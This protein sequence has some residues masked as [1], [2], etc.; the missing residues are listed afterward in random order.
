MS[1]FTV[2]LSLDAETELGEA[3]LAAADRNAVVAAEAEI[4][5]RLKGA[6]ASAGR[7]LHE[8]LRELS[9]PPLR[10]LFTVSEPDRTV[11][12][13]TVRLL[14]GEARA[15]RHGGNGRPGD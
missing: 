10:M 4:F 12:V 2:I 1:S 7:D 5:R 14:P 15:D 9:F 13:E 6:P 8:G 11:E 3:Y